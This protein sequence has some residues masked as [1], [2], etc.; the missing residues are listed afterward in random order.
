M[1]GYEQSKWVAERLVQ[2]AI[3]RNLVVGDIMRLGMVGW[4]SISGLL[5]LEQ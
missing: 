5:T 1:G 3:E 2:Q 4:H